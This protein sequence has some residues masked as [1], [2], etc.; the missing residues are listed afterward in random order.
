MH[1]YVIY[2]FAW[3]GLVMLAILNGALR[4]KVYG[5]SLSELSAHQLSTLFGLALFGIYIY[6]LT[7]LV[8]LASSEQALAIGAMW[9][10]MTIIFEFIFGHYVM[11]HSWGHLLA[12]YN[13]FKGRVWIFVLLFTLFSPCLF[14][15]LRS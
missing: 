5:P 13:L 1:T 14:Y 11:G 6:F 3:I 9:V 4:E 7:G 10:I 8:R 12:D 2:A 15:K